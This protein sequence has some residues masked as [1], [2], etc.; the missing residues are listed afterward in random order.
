MLSPVAVGGSHSPLWCAGFSL[1]WLLLSR[2]QVLGAWGSVAAAH[3]LSCSESSG[4]FLDQGSIPCPPHQQARRLDLTQDPV[5]SLQQNLLRLVPVTSTLG[6]FKPGQ[7]GE[8]SEEEV[9]ASCY[10]TFSM[11]HVIS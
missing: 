4:I 2:G 5:R 8:G 3:G 1:Q 9:R 6:T 10:M 11:V 7:G